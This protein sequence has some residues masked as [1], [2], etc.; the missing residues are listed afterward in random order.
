MYYTD[1]PPL[2]ALKSLLLNQALDLSK[3]AQFV[4]EQLLLNTSILRLGGK[5]D[6][7]L[8]VNE[9]SLSSNN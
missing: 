8:S 9:A 1:Y 2:L 3:Q 7:P 4:L 5:V 6:L